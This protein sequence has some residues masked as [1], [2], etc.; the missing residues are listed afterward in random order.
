MTQGFRSGINGF[1]ICPSLNR[2]PLSPGVTH[3]C[4]GEGLFPQFGL[5][6]GWLFMV[7]IDSCIPSLKLGVYGPVVFRTAPIP[8]ALVT[9]PRQLLLN[10]SEPPILARFTAKFPGHPPAFLVHLV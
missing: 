2:H 7:N 3:A 5:F 8:P 9:G 6:K 10:L 1:P 4:E